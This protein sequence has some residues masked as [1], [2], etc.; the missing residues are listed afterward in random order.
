MI[1]AAESHHASKPLLVPV[2]VPG[3]GRGDVPDRL[4]GRR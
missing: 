2:T 1:R 3:A 4:A